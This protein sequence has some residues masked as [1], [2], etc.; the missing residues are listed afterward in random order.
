MLMPTLMSH[1]NAL[2]DIIHRGIEFGYAKF[3]IER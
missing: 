1:A 3:F 2:S